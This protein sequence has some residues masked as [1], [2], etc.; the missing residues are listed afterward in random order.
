MTIP[1]K[2]AKRVLIL[3]ITL[4]I[5]T[6]IAIMVVSGLE[7]GDT[8]IWEVLIFY[9]C[10]LLPLFIISLVWLAIYYK[11]FFSSWLGWFL[12]LVLLF[13]SSYPINISPFSLL[14]STF[15]LANIFI[16]G[17]ATIMLLWHNDVGLRLLGWTSA[18]LFWIFVLAWRFQGDLILLWTDILT[19]PENYSPL[20][21]FNPLF[22]ASIWI[23]PL[24]ALGFIFHT[25]R[26]MWKEFHDAKLASSPE[27]RDEEL[28][29][30]NEHL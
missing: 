7:V 1:T 10:G 3:P 16:F 13:V 6:S 22:C 23:I 9:G 15:F 2:K 28:G 14:F 11:K 26:I 4:L 21:W 25:F 24:S 30:S 8:S 19:N 29:C 27:F 20:W 12:S 5:I 17:I 18:L